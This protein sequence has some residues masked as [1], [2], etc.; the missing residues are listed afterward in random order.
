MAKEQIA[1]HQELESGIQ[2]SSNMTQMGRVDSMVDD[3]DH[4]DEMSH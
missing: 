3:Y 1:R 2:S 4:T